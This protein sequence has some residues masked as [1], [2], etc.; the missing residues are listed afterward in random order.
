VRKDLREIPKTKTSERGGLSRLLQNY[1]ISL[2][3]DEDLRRCYFWEARR[4]GEREH[5]RLAAQKRNARLVKLWKAQWFGNLEI[6]ESKENYNSPSGTRKWH[7]LSIFAIVQGHRFIWWRSE[8]HFDAG[9][10]PM[11]E[12]FFAG[13]SGLAGLSPLD[14]REL[15]KEE[16]N[17]V[18][19]IFGRGLLDQRKIMLLALHKGM[20]EQLEDVVL[21]VCCDSKN[22]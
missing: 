2:P 10:A 21:K 13:H 18:T 16:I 14:L 8:K 15:T 11:G 17:L 3:T 12:I 22:E 7:W 6:K 19:C 9:E 20:K 5:E 4:N 1:F